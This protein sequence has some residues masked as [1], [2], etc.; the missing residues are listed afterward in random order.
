MPFRIVDVD[1]E[2]L[3]IVIEGEFG[4]QDILDAFKALRRE[5]LSDRPRRLWDV[6]GATPHLTS[7]DLRNLGW[8]G[9]THDRVPSRLAIL[10][11]Q[12]VHFGLARAHEAFRESELAEVKVFRDEDE[13]LAWL[14]G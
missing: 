2:P 12:D 7:D 6:R 5:G 4:Y 11:D 9:Q 10:V 8:E 14:K 1:G 3:R 13:A